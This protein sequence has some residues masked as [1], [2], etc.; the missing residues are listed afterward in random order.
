MDYEHRE[1]AKMKRIEREVK[2]LEAMQKM[3]M[4][5]RHKCHLGT[6]WSGEF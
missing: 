1:Y 6:I 2:E 3:E 5:P 4:K